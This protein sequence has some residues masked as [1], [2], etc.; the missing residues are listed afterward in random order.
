[1]RM[2]PQTSA[3]SGPRWLGA[4]PDL[5]AVAAET[6][7]QTA[8]ARLYEALLP[9]RGRLVIWGG[10]NAVNGPASHYLGLLAAR[11]GRPDDAVTHF[12]DAIG[13]AERIGARPELARSLVE[14]GEALAR[15]GGGGA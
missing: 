14:L 1:E 8:A 12:E 5:S 2:P 11:L 4:V 3:A 13:L 10:A 6:G 9:F 7:G 15:R